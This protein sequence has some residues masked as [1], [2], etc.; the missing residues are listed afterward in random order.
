MSPGR[1]HKLEQVQLEQHKPQRPLLAT[2]VPPE[3]QLLMQLALAQRKLPPQ[4]REQ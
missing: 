4:P 2:T 3:W 1:P